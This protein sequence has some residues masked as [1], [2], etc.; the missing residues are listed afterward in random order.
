MKLSQSFKQSRSIFHRA[1]HR[2]IARQRC[3]IRKPLLQP[4]ISRWFFSK[5]VCFSNVCKMRPLTPKLISRLKASVKTNGK[6][7]AQLAKSLDNKLTDMGV[8]VASITKSY[9]SCTAISKNSILS[10]TKHYH[11]LSFRNLKYLLCTTMS[12]QALHNLIIH[13][14]VLLTNCAQ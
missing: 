5:R 3:I 13:Y 1:H 10:F 2:L 8:R 4:Q 6:R 9:R 11:D 7:A 12:Y 14:H